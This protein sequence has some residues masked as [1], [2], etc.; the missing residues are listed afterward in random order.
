MTDVEEMQAWGLW[1]ERCAFGLL[2]E[3]DRRGLEKV[4]GDR[5]RSRVKRLN[6]HG[7]GLP[8]PEDRDCAHWFESWCALHP[9]KDGKRYKDWLLTRGR[10][11]LDTIQSGVMLLVRN[12]VREWVRSFHTSSMDL[13]LDEPLPEAHGL[14][15]QELLP[16]TKP[17]RSPELTPWIQGQVE[18]LTAGADPVVKAVLMVRGQGRVF[19]HPQVR[20][21]T[22]YAKTTLHE[23]H[24]RLLERLAGD[25][26]ASFPALRPQQA[27]AAVLDVLDEAGRQLL[28]KK[29]PET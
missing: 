7:A 24:H 6:A 5:F 19:S 21:E 2:G 4:V 3:E 9:R 16:E 25:L 29:D 13:S 28:L 18:V 8:R 22:G 14:S 10:R 11:D 1:R 12:V 27:S 26:K 23:Q 15:L 17:E 20:E